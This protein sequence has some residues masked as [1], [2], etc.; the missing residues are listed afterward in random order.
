MSG[1]VSIKP[2]FLKLLC[3]RFTRIL[4]AKMHVGVHD[5]DVLPIENRLH[6]TGR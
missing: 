1:D 5:Q 3:G 2:I 6:T 4:D